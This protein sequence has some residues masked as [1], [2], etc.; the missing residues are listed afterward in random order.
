MTYKAPEEQRGPAGAEPGSRAREEE[1]VDVWWGSYAARTMIPSILLSLVFTLVLVGYISYLGAWREESLIRNSV[2]GVLAALW[3]LLLGWWAYRLIATTYRLT[4][5]RLICAVNFG[6]HSPPDQG[7]LL[8]DITHVL[9][10]KNLLE[11]FLGVG[12]IRV[13][14]VHS[15]RSGVMM[16]GVRNTAHVALMIRRQIKRERRL[17]RTNQ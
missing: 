5:K 7:I 12:R 13:L 15:G 17:V 9:V 4:T 10:Q 8:R 2:R 1:E 11:R 6:L 3:S 14:T 16:N